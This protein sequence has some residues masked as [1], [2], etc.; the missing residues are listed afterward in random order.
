MTVRWRCVAGR[1]T[2]YHHPQG[3]AFVGCSPWLASPLFK[4]AQVEAVFDTTD[5]WWIL[6]SSCRIMCGCRLFLF[7]RGGGKQCPKT[8]SCSGRFESYCKNNQGGTS[9]ERNYPENL[10]VP[11]RNL[12]Q[13]MKRIF[14]TRFQVRFQFF[15]ESPQGRPCYKEFLPGRTEAVPG[16]QRL[17][18]FRSPLKR[19]S[20]PRVTSIG[21][22]LEK[23]LGESREH[24]ERLGSPLRSKSAQIGAPD[25]RSGVGRKGSP[26][27]VPISP[28]SSDL[29]RFAI[30]VF[31]NAPMCSD[32]FRL[33]ICFQN[34]SK[35][36]RETLSADNLLQVPD[37]RGSGALCPWM[38]TS[39]TMWLKR[40]SMGTCFALCSC[41]ELLWF[42]GTCKSAC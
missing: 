24:P 18:L 13:T 37:Q 40:T 6:F 27:F 30:P 7:S 20:T 42:L 34:K 14:Q 22:L 1:V 2:S 41:W 33:A 17:L 11:K 9:A 25:P 4:I 28:F 12:K 26:R 16:K 29:F 8:S 39:G 23:H 36:I 10:W 19:T 3:R 21:S 31:G 32:L 38:M 5:Y 35:Q 15:H